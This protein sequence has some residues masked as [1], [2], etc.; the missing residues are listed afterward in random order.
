MVVDN[1]VIS[2]LFLEEGMRDNS[3]TDPYV[4]TTP[5]NV[6]EYVS[7]NVKVGATV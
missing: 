4:E 7:A 3:D 6:L 1:G 5:E 2:K